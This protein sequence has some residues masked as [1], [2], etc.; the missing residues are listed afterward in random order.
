MTGRIISQM[1]TKSKA[2][3]HLHP[4]LYWLPISINDEERVLDIIRSDGTKFCIEDREKRSIIAVVPFDYTTHKIV[5]HGSNFV[6]DLMFKQSYLYY[7]IETID[8]TLNEAMEALFV[9]YGLSQF[10]AFTKI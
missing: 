7:I 9:K 3:Q 1:E 2:L 6:T 5:D 4:K 10:F 8:K